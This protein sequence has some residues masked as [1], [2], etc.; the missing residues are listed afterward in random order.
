MRLGYLHIGPSWHGIVRYGRLLA[1]EASKRPDMSVVEAAVTLGEDRQHNHK[2]LLDAATQL[3]STEVVHIQF[4]YV[5]NKSLWGHDWQQLKYLRFFIRNCS[6]PI[7]VTLHDLHTPPPSFKAALSKLKG[8]QAKSTEQQTVL[9]SSDQGTLARQT[10]SRKVS[11]KSVESPAA[12]QSIPL[13]AIRFLRYL[14]RPN[15]LS[16]YWLL[17]QARLTFVC[18]GEEA[19]RLSHLSDDSRTICIPHFIEQ[20]SSTIDQAKAKELLDLETGKIVTL[21]GFIHPIKGHRL[22]IEAL[23]HLS[24]DVTVVFAGGAQSPGQKQFVKDLTALAEA[25]GVHKRLKVTGYLSEQELEY[26]LLATDLAVCPFES[27]CASG[28]LSTWLSLAQ[29]ILAY[30]LPQIAEYNAYEPG[31]IH[32]FH[33]YEATALAQSIEHILATVSQDKVPA[34]VRLQQRLSLPSVFDQHLTSYGNVLPH[35]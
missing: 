33:S 10:A 6:S 4:S 32:V 8:S 15:V 26:Y 1:S 20:R 31:A 11:D 7:V 14:L 35:C 5:N 2:L 19:K 18:S 28:S 17:K 12:Q 24:Q 25:K 3:S 16:L 29:P 9:E 34:G 13:R 23:P 27:M 21:L 30:D 22:M